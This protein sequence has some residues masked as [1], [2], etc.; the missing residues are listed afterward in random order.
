MRDEGPPSGHL[1]HVNSDSGLLSVSHA[2]GME[3]AA[4]DPSL[5][6][7]TPQPSLP[8]FKMRRQRCR[9]FM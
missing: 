6:P 5:S 3:L 1:L 2:P 8:I 4:L 7:L 9:T